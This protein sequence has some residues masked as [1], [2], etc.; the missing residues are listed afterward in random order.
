VNLD[1]RAVRLGTA[2]KPLGTYTLPYVATVN[3]QC[4]LTL[5]SIGYSTMGE[6]IKQVFVGEILFIKGG[7]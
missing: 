4:N 1:E 3:R 6:A 5:S 7:N 2:P